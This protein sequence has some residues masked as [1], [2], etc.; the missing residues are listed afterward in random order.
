[1]LL[2][3][4]FILSSNRLRLSIQ[5][6]HG[7]L[8]IDSI[9]QENLCLPKL[10]TRNYRAYAHVDGTSPTSLFMGL[11]VSPPQCCY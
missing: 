6:D 4:A 2:L 7:S 8:D 3:N 1:L 5:L 10:S 11:Q 9:L